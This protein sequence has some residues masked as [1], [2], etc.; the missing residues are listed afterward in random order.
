M[1]YLLSEDEMQIHRDSLE[2][3]KYTAISLN[4]KLVKDGD[5]PCTP[6][7]GGNV[8]YYCDKCKIL[9][10]CVLDKQFPKQIKEL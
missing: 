3:V 8:Q 7:A 1:Q 10:I 2:M 6:R 4:R 9:L 5:Y